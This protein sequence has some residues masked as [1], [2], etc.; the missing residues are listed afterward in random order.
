MNRS[1]CSAVF[2][3]HEIETFCSTLVQEGV[4]CAST[5]ALLC[6]CLET[7]NYLNTNPQMCAVPADGGD[8]GLLFDVINR[9]LMFTGG[10]YWPF[11]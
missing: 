10:G 4:C 8:S 5:W 3:S 1:H 11:L 2:L 7:L 9:G 6:H